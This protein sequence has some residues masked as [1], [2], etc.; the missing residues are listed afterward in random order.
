MKRADAWKLAGEFAAFARS[1]C[2]YDTG[3]MHNTIRVEAVSPTE[4]RVIIGGD[5]AP[6]APYT[7]EPW[8]SERW[9]GKKNPNEGWIDNAVKSF[10][11]MAA[12]KIRGKIERG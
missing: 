9:H 4:V 3:N 10:V 2:P 6:Y 11:E 12:K 8:I 7:N 5:P 1:V